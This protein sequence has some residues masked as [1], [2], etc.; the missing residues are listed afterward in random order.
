MCLCVSWMPS[1]MCVSILHIPG[2]KCINQLCK[3]T[4][5][6][7][8]CTVRNQNAHNSRTHIRA[9]PPVVLAPVVPLK[10]RIQGQWFIKLLLSRKCQA[11]GTLLCTDANPGLSHGAIEKLCTWCFT[12]LQPVRFQSSLFFLQLFPA[13]RQSSA[14]NGKCLKTLSVL[15][16]LRLRLFYG[17]VVNCF[18]V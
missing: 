18:H 9:P 6:A 4:S 1:C 11:K 16:H 7:H 12:R 5:N 14:K 2:D 8:A 10:I 13:C 15:L 17:L 3:R